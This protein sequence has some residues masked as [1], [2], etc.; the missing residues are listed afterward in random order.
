MTIRGTAMTPTF[1]MKKWRFSDGSELVQGIANEK[2]NRVD[3]E[4][5]GFSALLL[6]RKWV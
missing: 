4:T 2:H 1:Q 5:A 3:P 6:F